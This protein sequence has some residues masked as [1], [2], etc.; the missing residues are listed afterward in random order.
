MAAGLLMGTNGAWAEEIRTSVYSNDFNT[1]SDW[2]AKGKT[3][4]WTCNPGTTTANTFGSQ[5]IG[6]GAGTGDMGLVSP[7][8]TIPGDIKL[9]DVELKFKMDACTS[10]KSSGID[11]I[12]SD[13][14]INNG[15]VSSGTPFFSINASAS[16]NGYW[17]TITVGGNDYKT[18]LNGTGTF[19]NNSLN[20]NTTGI[21]V[22]NV[23]FNF[24]SKTAT[25]TLKR[26]DETV[27]VS[28]TVASFA[29]A[30]AT[31][32]DRIFLHAG[33]TYGGVTIDDVNV[34]KVVSDIVET[35]YTATFTESNSLVPTVNIFSD[36][37]RTVPV[38]NG[39]LEDATTYYYTASLEGYTDYQGSFT[40]SGANPDV[41]FTMTAKPRYTFT[42]NLVNSVGGAVIETIYTDDDSYDGKTQN[43]NFS[44]YLTDGSNRV[45]YSKDDDTYSASYTS[46]SGDATKNVPYTAYDGV[47]YFF[48]GES[49]AALGTK[50][51]HGN[52]SGNTA[53]RGLNNNT[54]NV[55][56]IPVSGTYTLSY[57]VC[58][59]NTGSARTYSFYKNDDSNVIET[60]SCTW[61]VNYVKSSGTKTVSDI[62]FAA[63][64]VLQFYSGDT[65]II[66]DYVI[67]TLNSVPVTVGAAGYATYVNNDNDLDFSATSIE[68]YKVKVTAKGVATMTK[69][70]NVPAGTPVL[71][72]KDGG[73]T[74][75][76]PVMT[77]AATVTGNDLVPGTDAAVATTDG[78]STNMILN[79]K[80]GNVGF[81]YAN[82]QTVAANRAYL[83]FD[84]SYKP[85]SGAPMMLVFDNETTGISE[86]ETMR[87]VE[88]EIF[89]DLQGRKVAQLTKGLYIVNGKKV[90]K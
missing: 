8:I 11:F 84:S 68:A 76:I 22:L 49:F 23:R 30:S 45:T 18:E 4:G 16:G 36:S 60:Q 24:T 89:F 35:T 67:L 7:S 78:G 10:G 47:A 77:G 58:S 54:I 41:N 65:N 56:T 51:N 5:V 82:G 31:T 57:A 26:T 9:V 25:F 40:V 37:E 59:N 52:Y 88:N 73:D 46:A 63:G 6:V 32:L 14:N 55:M 66:L 48:E 53:G 69:V 64:D 75:N 79:N 43:V 3:D 86:I 15:Y 71:L 27:L 29:N 12:T 38:V 90:I 83:H 21:V 13:V 50:P 74:E 87:N 20:R 42:V 61:S 39:T 1:S 81:Y 2:T 19:E 62:S 72:Y 17:G 33:K 70:D 44:K 28:S 80:G 85:G 34:Y